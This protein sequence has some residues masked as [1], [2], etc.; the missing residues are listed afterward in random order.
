[1]LLNKR[2]T[3]E[4]ALSHMLNG[5]QSREMTTF[6]RLIMQLAAGT[7]P[8]LLPL[9]STATDSSDTTFSCSRE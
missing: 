3:A 6:R 7:H 1:M 8:I 4:R 9:S 5:F 2:F